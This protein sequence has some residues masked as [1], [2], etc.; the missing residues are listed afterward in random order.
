MYRSRRLVYYTE[1]GNVR[2][3]VEMLNLEAG[4]RTKWIE[5]E[6]GRLSSVELL[7][8]DRYV[9]KMAQN[10]RLSRYEDMIVVLLLPL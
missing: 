4:E 1:L 9:V 2:G 8:S 3:R 10:R 6:E 5:Q 7:M